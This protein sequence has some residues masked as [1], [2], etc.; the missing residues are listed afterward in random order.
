VTG[1]GPPEPA[2]ETPDPA[3]QQ[4]AERLLRDAHPLLGGLVA[5]DVR[6]GAV[7]LR[8]SYQRRRPAEPEPLTRAFAPAASV[9]KLV[10]AIALLE[11]SPVSL[12]TPVCIRGGEHAIER[13][14]LERPPPKPPTRCRPFSEALGF[15]RNAVFAQLATQHLLRRDLVEVAE[16]L[17]FNAALAFDPPAR[18]GELTVPYNDLA[19]GRAAAG[20]TGSSLSVL[21]AAR[22]SQI[23]ASGGAPRPLTPRA[24]ASPPGARQRLMK[25]STAR[26]LRRMMEV[27]VHSGTSVDA[28]TNEHGGSYL[29]DVR[30]AGKTGTLQ[31]EPGEPITS[32]FIGF[33]PSRS[34]QIA[35]AVLLQNAPVWRRKANAVARDL[36]RAYFRD[37]RGVSPPFAPE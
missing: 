32:W 28:F 18:L 20:F 27:T 12:S 17:G 33:A 6:T 35:L 14:H 3:L 30:I 1:K 34:P 31:P 7:L 26:Q 15:S 37:R 5:I 23:I 19:F 8:E 29:G 16:R 9:F 11:R 13:E 25:R 4:V 21:G 24:E 2:S 10:T 22:L 36:L